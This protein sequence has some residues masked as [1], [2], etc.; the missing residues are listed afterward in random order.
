MKSHLP[1]LGSSTALYD[2]PDL[3]YVPGDLVRLIAYVGMGGAFRLQDSS[4]LEGD[5]AAM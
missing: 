3:P 5:E 1:G 4:C 2:T